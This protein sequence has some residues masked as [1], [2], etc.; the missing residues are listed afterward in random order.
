MAESAHRPALS[1][2]SF[3]NRSAATGLGVTLAGTIEGIF[4]SSAAAGAELEAAGYG[5]LVMDPKGLLS[6]PPGFSYTVVAQEGVTMLDSGEPTPGAA[7]GTASFSRRGGDGAVLVNN[8]E[9][10]FDDDDVP[11]PHLE[12]LVYDPGS[13]GGTTNIEVDAEGNRVREYVSLA[14]TEDN[15]AGGVTPWHTWL[16]CE[17]TEEVPGPDNTLQMRH[18]YVFEVD[19]Q[20]PDNNRDP[21]PIMALGRYPHEAVAI[22]P[23][24]GV[25]YLTEDASEPHGLVYRWTPPRSALPL[26]RGSLRALGPAD[27]RL[28]AMRAYT[29]A[30]ELVTDLSVVSRVG[31]TLYT[32]WSEVADRD[33]TTTSTRMQFDY[34]DVT[35][36]PGGPVT[37]SRK[38]EGAWWGEGGAYIVASYARFEDGSARRHDGQVWLLNPLKQT[39]ELRLIFAYTP[40]QNTDPDGPD[41][42]TVSPYGG[43][44][45]AED[46]DGKQHLVG[47]GSQGKSFFFARN[48]IEGDSEFT[49][50]NF[51]PDRRTL[52][53]NVQTP[54]HVFAIR[55]P[56]RAP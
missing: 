42:I 48:E 2:R 32:R 17:E 22:D 18:G 27:G 23:Y 49:G 4:G 31:T 44:I 26:G 13:R 43:V 35:A 52:F 36:T 25:I 19:P 11:V 21:L 37:R 51:S 5:P 53:A 28:E 10:A 55:G 14:G 54:G 15:C 38:L 33:A 3:L 40:N 8:H 34:D 30:G 47:A 46:G 24:E 41:N 12:G 6:L 29:R 39:L 9:L 7:D 56:F 45:L 50:P 16:T 20:Y 1:R